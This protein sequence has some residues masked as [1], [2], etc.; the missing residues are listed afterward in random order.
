VNSL[1]EVRTDGLE[2]ALNN[3]LAEDALRVD[4]A[5]AL[6]AIGASAKA[7]VP[8]L[9]KDLESGELVALRSMDYEYRSRAAEVLARIPEA[10]PALGSV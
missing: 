5:A 10:G 9:M 8:G 2:K 7:A 6:V 1:D 3:A 4:A